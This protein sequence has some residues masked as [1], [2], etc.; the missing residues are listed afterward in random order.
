MRHA[1]LPEHI[2]V[3]RADNLNQIEI[4]RELAS[5]PRINRLHLNLEI[6][7]LALIQQRN[8]YFL[9]EFALVG[10]DRRI[11]IG[12]QPDAELAQ[13][14]VCNAR[15]SLGNRPRGGL[16]DLRSLSVR[17]LAHVLE[18]VGPTAGQAALGVDLFEVANGF[19]IAPQ[20]VQ[21]DGLKLTD[22]PNIVAPAT[23]AGVRAAEPLLR[24][25]KPNLSLSAGVHLLRPE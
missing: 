19:L 1:L 6:P 20:L 2:A 14:D 22:R 25:E 9:I 18:Q 10:V 11:R 5:E 12:N 7:R 13:I 4:G 24:A 16:L 23:T 15:L 3:S 17:F 8:L 21:G